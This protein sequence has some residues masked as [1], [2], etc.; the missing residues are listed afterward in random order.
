[1]SY[2]EKRYRIQLGIIVFTV[3]LLAVIFLKL[4]Y[5][6]GFVLLMGIIALAQFGLDTLCLEY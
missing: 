2:V 5:H 1:M 3:P 6:L 4:N